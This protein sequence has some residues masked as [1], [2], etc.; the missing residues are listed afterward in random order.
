M[1]KSF[2]IPLFVFLTF[3]PIALSGK[4]HRI[5]R[6]YLTSLTDTVIII[7]PTEPMLRSTIEVCFSFRGKN[8]GVLARKRELTLQWNRHS[9]KEYSFV[10]FEPGSE[11]MDDMVDTRFISVTIGN[12][13]S[14][15]EEIIET[16]K[17]THGIGLGQEEN[18][19]LL[20][21][22]NDRVEIGLGHRNPAIFYESD[23]RT[24]PDDPLSIQTTGSV[25]V[26]ETVWEYET[27]PDNGLITAI[28]R[29][30]VSDSI[31]G[32][33]KAGA[34]HAGIWTYLDRNMDNDYAR[35]GGRYKLALIPA[36]NTDSYLLVYLEG[37]ETNG[38]A[39]KEGMI[40]GKLKTTPFE[41]HY[42]LTWYD[43]KME[44]ID[45]DCHADISTEEILT[46][47]FPLLKSTIRFY[48]E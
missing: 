2:K 13:H 26:S 46:L 33:R 28:N 8:E 29:K 35:P 22:G 4:S 12:R 21:I 9:D 47:S 43:S 42:D 30:S 36:D 20:A 7:E 10:T 31:E 25:M 39:W 19:A 6:D 44:K 32:W 27:K 18:V 14:G 17:I 41:N 40:K 48:K 24:S 15:V 37:A 5:Y 38:N 1:K 45:R 23:M 16:R 3:L 34:L 11:T